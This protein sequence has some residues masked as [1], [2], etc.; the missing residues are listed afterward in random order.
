VNLLG[1]QVLHAA[2]A[3]IPWPQSSPI[4]KQTWLMKS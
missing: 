2:N 4:S 3:G 1:H